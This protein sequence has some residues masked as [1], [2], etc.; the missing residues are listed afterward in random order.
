MQAE[1]L[2]DAFRGRDRVRQDSKSNEPPK[3]L[4]VFLEVL[5]FSKMQ[6][7]IDILAEECYDDNRAVHVLCMRKCR[8]WQTSKTKDLVI[9]MSCG[10]KSHLP[11]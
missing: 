4:T 10:F 6:K 8:N 3:V 5:A 1:T 9:A 11:Q 7:R 2:P